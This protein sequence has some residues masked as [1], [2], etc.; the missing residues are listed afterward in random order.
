MRRRSLLALPA[1]LSAGA[2]AQSWPQGPIR[3]ISPFTPGGASDLLGRFAAQAI[4]GASGQT[5]IVE[6]RTGAGGNVGMEAVARAA[7]D[8]R[9]LVV[10][11]GAAAINQTLYRNLSF[12][13]LRDFAPV[14]LLGV[15]PNVLAVHPALPIRSAAEFAAF[16]HSMRGGITYGSAGIGTIPHLAMALLL[17]RIGATGTHV[18]YR[19]S[20]PAITDL[21]AGNLQAVLENLPPMAAQLHAGGIRGLG[22]STAQRIPDWPDL[23]TIAE[24]MP[25]PGFEVVAW[26]SLLAPAG[27]PPALIEAMAAAIR[28]AEATPDGQAQIARIGALPRPM[29]VGEFG[30]FL[31]AE[32]AIWAEA[33]RLTGATV[34]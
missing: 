24:A 10:A 2:R 12:D 20:A 17:R 16:A 34:E 26:Q 5:V 15:V 8:G 3:I 6:N 4:A 32:V 11:A 33:V 22:V 14:S 13:L 21:V 9:T 18:P 25:L 28:I 7:P 23:P 30:A 31:A 1:L 19:G 29:S 27:T